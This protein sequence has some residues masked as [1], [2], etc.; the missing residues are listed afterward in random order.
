MRAKLLERSSE[1]LSEQELLEMLL[2]LNYRRQDVKPIVKSLFKHFGSLGA[3]CDASPTELARIP[4]LG[5]SGITLLLLIKGLFYRLDQEQ[6]SGRSVL[7]NWKAVQNF[8]IRRLG[9][10]A[11]E[12]FM[13]LYL[14]A[15]NGVNEDAIFSIGTVNRTAVFPREVVK[16]ALDHQAV[17]QIVVHNHLSSS[18]KPSDADIML[19]RRIRDALALVD[20]ALHDY[21]IATSNN[22]SSMKALNLL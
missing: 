21:L 20:I 13:I 3:I 7:S 17:S 6:V 14:D 1:T 18:T 19:T 16:K 22:V 12:K 11:V 15:Q 8:C 9:Y 2:F 4:N 10:S 5:S